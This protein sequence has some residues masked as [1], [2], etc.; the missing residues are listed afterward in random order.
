MAEIAV[1]PTWR[2]AGLEVR[3]GVQK[4]ILASSLSLDELEFTSVSCHSSM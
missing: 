1:V 3:V 4:A 2:R